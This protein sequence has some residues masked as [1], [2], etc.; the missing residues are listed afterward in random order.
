MMPES[1]IP[2]PQPP[3][4][5]EGIMVKARHVLFGKPRNIFEPGIFHRLSLVAILAWI[6]LGADGLSSSSYG[7]E[8]AFRAL[9][10]HTYLAFGLAAATAITVFIIA[11][12]YSRIIEEFPAG[13][14]GYLVASKLLGPGLGVL[15][16]CALLVDYALTIAVSI[17]SAGDN[18][19]SVF[20]AEW[21]AFKLPITLFLI[22][23][24]TV[25]NIRGVRESVLLLAPIFILFVAT[26]AIL[27][28]AGVFQH[29]SSLPSVVARASSD[30][31][32]DVGA[33]GLGAL[34]LVFI[35]AY[36][37]GG[38]TYTGI[39]AVSNA[40]PIMREPRVHTARRT[41]LYMAASLAVTAG[42]LL[43]CYLL[44]D[45]MPAGGKTMNAVLAENVARSFPYAGTY[46]VVTLFAAGA[47]LIVGAQ[48]GFIDGPRVLANMAVDSWVPRHFSTLSERFTTMNGIVL[49]GLA[50]LALVLYTRGNIHSLVVMYSINVFLTFSLSMFGMLRLWQKR[51]GIK[52]RTRRLIHFGAAFMLCATVLGITLFEKFRVGGWLTIAITGILVLFCFGIRAHYRSVAQHLTKFDSVLTDL[53]F[54]DSAEPP[55]PIDPQ[56]RTAAVLVSGYGGLG[57]HTVINVF[58]K[59]PGHFRNVVFISVA[60]VDSGEM[61]GVEQIQALRDRTEESLERYVKLAGQFGY[62]AVYRMAVGTDVVDEA[63][64]LCM[65]TLKEFPTTMF[66]AGQIL[67]RQEA[68]YHPLLHNR[69]AFSVQRRLFLEGQTMVVLPMRM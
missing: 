22:A 28:A 17:T 18:M 58:R 50:S 51:R 26:H 4:K 8:E 6:G 15:S 69:T 66:F 52:P 11:S 10:G 45:V 44:W 46:V 55:R 20:P 41:M 56:A 38:G 23:L 35:R 68:W 27:I 12:G 29:A 60:V 57:V 13:G 32:T 54:R 24:L 9:S 43:V 16:G 62:P 25:L 61:K 67:F 7:P 5:P 3:E 42:G 53:P 33:L 36:S 48:A 39:E 30:F 31:K 37:M 34:L 64:N 59:F 21:Q 63:F 2:A 1:E 40:M 14:G 19:F 65:Q 49:M 47:L